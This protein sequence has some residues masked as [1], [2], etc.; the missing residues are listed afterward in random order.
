MKNDRAGRGLSRLD[1]RAAVVVCEPP[2]IPADLD[3][4]GK[5]ES[6]PK[7]LGAVLISFG[8][9]GIAIPGPFPPGTVFVLL[10]V[11]FCQPR[12]VN[13]LAGRLARKCPRSFRCLTE[14]VESLRVDLERRYPG[15]VTFRAVDR[16][17]ARHA[18]K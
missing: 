10:G 9:I 17:S 6:L 15:S 13:G 2:P 18:R 1:A 7:D 3:L 11:L 16:P 5:I 4:A 8:L 14:F 12:W